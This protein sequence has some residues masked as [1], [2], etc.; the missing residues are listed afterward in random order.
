MG[1]IFD[2]EDLYKIVRKLNGGEI[3]PIG[4]THYDDNAAFRQREIQELARL[5]IED[6]LHVAKVEGS[7]AS[8]AK[9]RVKALTWVGEIIETFEDNL[10]I[11]MVTTKEAR[12]KE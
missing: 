4:D 9:A 8:I 2:A 7:E 5:L 10:D 12:D 11:K 1:D 6:I 3:R